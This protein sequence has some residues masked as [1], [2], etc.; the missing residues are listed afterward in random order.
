MSS[1]SPHQAAATLA[2][3]AGVWYLVAA[4]AGSRFATALVVALLGVALPLWYVRNC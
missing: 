4:G 2:V 3:L 1:R